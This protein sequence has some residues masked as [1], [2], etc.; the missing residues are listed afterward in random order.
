MLALF[1]PTRFT[2]IMAGVV[3]AAPHAIKL[4]ADGI[5]RC[6]RRRSRAVVDRLGRPWQKITKVQL[7]MA[8]GRGTGS[9]L[10]LLYV[11]AMVVIG[12]M[13]GAGSLG[14][15]VVLGFSR[16]KEWGKGAAGGIAIV[17]LGVMLDRIAQTAAR[18]VTRTRC[19]VRS[20]TLR[21]AA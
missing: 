4:V 3:Y 18:P 11:L 16:S 15:D 13:V 14:Y 19:A 7:P 2:A 9:N 8:G 20:P 17:L 5:R 12:G 1:S 10:G 6:P 21:G